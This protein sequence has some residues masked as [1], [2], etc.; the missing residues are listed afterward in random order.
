VNLVLDGRVLQTA[1]L[2]LKRVNG[3]VELGIA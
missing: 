1:L 3:G 2:R